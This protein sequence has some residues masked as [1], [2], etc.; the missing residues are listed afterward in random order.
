ME[1]KFYLVP[2][3]DSVRVITNGTHEIIQKVSNH[4]FAFS[5]AF[6][7]SESVPLPDLLRFQKIHVLFL[8]LDPLPPVL[9]YWK[10]TR[11]LQIGRV[12]LMNTSDAFQILK[13]QWNSAFQQLAMNSIPKIRNC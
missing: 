8:E 13:K 5:A 12:K 4:S 7:F 6:V 9:G 2:E 1:S 11:N 10:H 3:I